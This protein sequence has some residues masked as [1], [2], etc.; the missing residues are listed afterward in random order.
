MVVVKMTMVKIIQM[1]QEVLAGQ[2]QRVV[3]RRRKMKM[4]L[5]LI[6]TGIPLVNPQIKTPN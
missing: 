3:W 5:I 6:I 4:G 2:H 1:M